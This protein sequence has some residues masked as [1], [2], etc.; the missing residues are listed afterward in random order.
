[1]NYTISYQEAHKHFVDIELVVEN[2]SSDKL[3]VQLAAW[4][5]GRYELQNFARNIQKFE[6]FDEKGNALAFQKTTRERW[7]VNS[8][9][10]K[11]VVIKYNCYCYQ[12][13]AGG[14]LLDD[15][16][17]YLNFVYCLM[18]IPGREDEKCSINLKVPNDYKI[19]CG[20]KQKGKVLYADNFLQV[21]DSPMI[22]SASLQHQ[23][24]EVG[25]TT[26]HIWVQG[27]MYQDWSRVLSD[28]KK[29]SEEQLKIF[30]DFP[31]E[32]YHFLFH[33]LPYKQHH[34]V[35]HRNST[36]ITIGPAEMIDNEAQYADFLSI[37]CHELFHAWNICKIRPVEMM[38]Y[39]LTKENYFESG[40][41]AE[42]VT[43]YYGE[44]L[45][46]RSGVC[47]EAFFMDEVNKNFKKHFE[48][49]ANH[50]NSVA[51]SSFDLWIDGYS[52]GI[53]NK[54]VSIYTKGALIAMT[55]D[56][57]IRNATQHKK[58]LDDVM[59]IMWGDFGKKGIGYS[60]ADFRKICESV[61]GLNFV[62]LFEECVF[63]T[64]D[65]KSRLN[66]AL[67][68]AGCVIDVSDS[69]VKIEKLFGLEV[70]TSGGK[71]IVDNTEP[72]SPADKVLAKD[73]EIIAIDKQKITGSINE[74]IGTK[75]KAEFTFFRK[76]RLL[77]SMIENDGKT[78]FKQHKILKKKTASETESAAY[79]RWLGLKS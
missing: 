12:M 73:D 74:L 6:A 1:M 5:P 16:Q 38:P 44:Y 8:K 61:S 51:A 14:C 24:Y 15:Q 42:G 78:Y 29:F 70:T 30:G 11:K 75:K 3:P 21:S 55:L 33:I 56:L 50:K 40:F 25:N 62:D 49:F 9:G 48:N 32:D 66:K 35:E 53:P 41:V 27:E 37:S 63:G 2:I 20:M 77:N 23:T 47:T 36:V 18:F 34:G 22:A 39:D 59:K 4:R 68:Y 67:G 19:A 7:E 10:L 43:T 54:K 69:K 72:G 76:N 52:A 28:F 31:E 64:T 71:V 58:S 13:D 45:L 57:E 79:Q 65:M 26:F 60:I 17:L 46:T